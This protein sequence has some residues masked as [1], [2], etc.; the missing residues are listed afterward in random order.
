LPNPGLSPDEML[1]ALR[2]VSEYGSITEAARVIGMHRETL[3][4][5][6]NRAREAISKGILDPDIA[7]R[8][9]EGHRVRGVSTL[10]DAEGAIKQQWVKTDIDA[11]RAA[12]ARE[13]ILSAMAEDLPR[14]EPVPP[15]ALFNADL[16]NLFTFTDFHLGMMAWHKEGGQDW[17]I[18]IAESVLRGAMAA[19]VRQ[20]PAAHTAIVNVQ[21]DFL[22]CD[23]LMPVTPG[24]GHVL[25]ADSRFPKVRQTAIRL[26][27]ELVQ[28]ALQTHQDVHLILA[29]GNHDQD[30]MGWLADSFVVHYEDDPRVTVNDSALPFYVIEWG[31]TML[32]VHH[33]HKVKNESLPLLFAAQFP[34]EWGRTRK[35]EIHC[36]HRHHRDEKE[37]NG[38][39]V[40]QHPTL[41]ARDA[42]A[43]RGGWIADRAAQ[44][45][46]YHRKYGQVGRVSVCPEMLAA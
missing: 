25:D 34:A 9:P 18:K 45:I 10:Y 40:I 11:Q 14:A 19:M 5:R 3:Q 37:Y 36:G 35:R 27:R 29:E 26:I 24:H 12:E 1:E 7:T 8:V 41:A 22:H 4:N 6:V 17:D 21:G 38:A 2:I 20:S 32:G 46:T 15:P 28:M 31:E 43:A 33:G 42:Y 23:G 16:C 44:A 39:V 30:S 13:A